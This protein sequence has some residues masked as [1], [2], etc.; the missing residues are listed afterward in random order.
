MAPGNYR[1]QVTTGRKAGEGCPTAVAKPRKK[2]GCWGKLPAGV[3]L[4][5]LGYSGNQSSHAV[6]PLVGTPRG[7]R[8]AGPGPACAACA[9]ASPAL[10]APDCVESPGAA[11]CRRTLR[12]SDKV[13]G[14]LVLWFEY[15]C[16]G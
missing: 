7:I 10:G 2:S 15:P 8:P 4:Y 3:A 13:N 14:S 16:L 11:A 1:L 5:G 12:D 9:I 6:G